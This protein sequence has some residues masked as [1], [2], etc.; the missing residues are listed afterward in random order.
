MYGVCPANMQNIRRPTLASLR[1]VP[2]PDKI[3]G[4][5]PQAVLSRPNCFPSLSFNS[6]KAA[7]HARSRRPFSSGIQPLLVNGMPALGQEG[8]S[9]LG[10]MLRAEQTPGIT[11]ESSTFQ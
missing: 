9:V 8:C 6:A 4:G 3:P 2:C 11:C 10:R 7:G 1:A 5:Y